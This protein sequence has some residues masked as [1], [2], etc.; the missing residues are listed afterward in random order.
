MQSPAHFVVGVAI[1]RAV[2]RRPL[3]LLLAFLS[4][5]V[6]DAIP[7]FEDPSILPHPLGRWACDYWT[8]ILASAQVATALLAVVLW[9]RGRRAGQAG[10]V[11]AYLI[12][13]GL[14]ACL[15]DYLYWIGGIE[16]IISAVNDLS[17]GWWFRPYIHIVRKHKEWRPLVV[18]V[19]L[20]LESLAFASGAWF[21]YR[22][23]APSPQ[24]E[25]P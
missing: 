17:H 2:P 5:F 23:T 7:H 3:G 18:A 8:A 14:V 19:C 12:I 21:A 25:Q 10:G 9:L 15:P 22:P 20:L 1:C 4:H 13:G 6:L 24:T 16:G 11:L